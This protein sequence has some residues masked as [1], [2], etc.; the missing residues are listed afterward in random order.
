VAEVC[1]WYLTEAAAGRILGRRNRPIKPSTLAMDR[2]R[3][4]THIKP[5]I[6]RRQVRAL[7]IADISGMQA[8]IAA[9]KTAKPRGDGRG[10]AT[11]G[12]TGVAARSVSTLQS[13]LS[14]AK[15][16]D[17]IESNPAVGGRKLAGK[18]KERR[19]SVA[20]IKK[21]GEAMRA[22]EKG[23]ERPVALAAVRLMLLTGFWISEAQGL[24]RAW[25][26][27]DEGY[28]V[29]RLQRTDAERLITI[30]AGEEPVRGLGQAPIGPQDR[31]QLRRQHDVAAFFCLSEI[32]AFDADRSHASSEIPH[33]EVGQQ[34]VRRGV[35]NSLPILLAFLAGVAPHNRLKL[36]GQAGLRDEFFD[37]VDL[38]VGQRIHRINEDGT[39]SAWFPGLAGAND[40]ID[41]RYEKAKRL[42]R[43][44]SC[45]N[46]VTLTRL[47]LGDGL[48]LMAMEP[49][50]L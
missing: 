4:E 22:A 33:H 9:G 32:A 44:C 35:C 36:G 46:H 48:G 39:G 1:D 6:G 16:L 14:H 5:L 28:G 24:Q 2:S 13:L 43:A 49:Q 15:L 21:L 12:G 8:D 42:A 7:K 30:T 20:E 10:G 19:L 26:H 47:S 45:R 29:G 27:A 23:G 37:L 3:I 38:A 40:R 11:T 34:N 17:V 31:Q 41:Y 25:L 50:G 18:R